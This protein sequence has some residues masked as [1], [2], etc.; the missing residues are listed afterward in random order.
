MCSYPQDA[1]LVAQMIG[2]AFPGVA[3]RAVLSDLA[4]LVYFET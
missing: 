1:Q 3:I 2:L 4:I